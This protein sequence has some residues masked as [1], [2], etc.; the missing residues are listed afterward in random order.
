MKAENMTV[1]DSNLVL[2]YVEMI[3]NGMAAC[4]SADGHRLQLWE[5]ALQIVK[6]DKEAEAVVFRCRKCGTELPAIP[7]YSRSLWRHCPCGHVA[8]RNP[9]PTT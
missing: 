8:T 7:G 2:R 5:T 4:P 6:E 1:T 9:L 3:R